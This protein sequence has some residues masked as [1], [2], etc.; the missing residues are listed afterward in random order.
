M[1][2]ARA[3]HSKVL[4]IGAGPS[5]LAM[6]RCLQRNQIAFDGVEISHGCGGLWD[7]K[8]PQSTIYESAHLISSK[9]KTEFK[10]F[11]MSEETADYPHHEEA[12]RYLQNFA[13]HFRLLDFFRF[14]T[15][16]LSVRPSGDHGNKWSVE[17]LD[18]ASQEKE[19]KHYQ[20]VI[21]ATGT[22]HHPYLPKIT[23]QEFY[24]GPIIHSA[25]YK[26]AHI[27]T[28]KRVL[29]VG[30]GNSGCDIAVDAVHRAKSVHISVRRGLHFVPKYLFGKPTD[31]LP[32][33]PLLPPKLKQIIDS[34]LLKKLSIDPARFGLPKPK[35]HLYEAHPVVN[36]L[37]L[38]HLGQG[39]IKVWPEI[40]ALTATGARFRNG[41]HSAYDVIVFATGFRPHFPFIEQNLLNWNNGCPELYLNI[42]HP[43]IH[44]LFL[45]GLLEAAGIGWQG[46]YE[47]AELI[48]NVLKAKQYGGRP[49][50]LFKKAKQNPV[51]LH[52]GID[53]LPIERMSYYVHKET[54]L[55]EIRKMNSKL[56]FAA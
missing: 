20:D 44:N 38:H 17:T 6:A 45:I 37:I 2:T 30:A 3:R 40:E 53:Y 50:D 26:Q 32:S 7:V 42:F 18:L 4:V 52:G 9:R 36:S 14:G 46:R 1:S 33:S 35:H 34:F 12:L 21:I 51:D 13:K 25:H 55:K 43:Y 27:F 41:K 54:Y 49:W 11:P 28:G 56:E 19:T 39:D 8:N 10:E 16:V 31:T 47:Q 48:C 23:G 5:G 24:Q 15:K 22:L 29:I